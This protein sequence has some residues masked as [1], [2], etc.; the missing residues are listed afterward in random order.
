VRWNQIQ[1]AATNSM[2]AIPNLYQPEAYQSD[3]SQPPL[4]DPAWLDDPSVVAMIIT[5]YLIDLKQITLLP[6]PLKRTG[7]TFLGPPNFNIVSIYL[8]T[9]YP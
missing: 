6:P 9:G 5:S 7:L 2:S 8:L 4:A 1:K 3:L